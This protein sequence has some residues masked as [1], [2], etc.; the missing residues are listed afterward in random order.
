[1]HFFSCFRTCGNCQTT[2]ISCTGAS[3]ISAC[4]HRWALKLS[5]II[6]IREKVISFIK[7]TFSIE[8]I[9]FNQHIIERYKILFS[10]SL[11]VMC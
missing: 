11:N 9:T 5:S 3:D 1:M 10:K 4:Q 8:E 6:Q 2:Q 7:K